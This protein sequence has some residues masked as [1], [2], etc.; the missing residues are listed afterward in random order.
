MKSNIIFS[1]LRAEMAR[2]EITIKQLA[3]AIGVTRDTMSRKLS[4]SAPI[5]LNEAFLINKRFF[6]NLSLWD[7][8]Q[9]LIKKTA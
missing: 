3:S 6:P 1:T 8:F 5:Y 9:E 4:G 7:L 2:N